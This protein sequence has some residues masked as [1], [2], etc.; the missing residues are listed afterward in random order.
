MFSSGRTFASRS[1]QPVGDS[2][3]RTMLRRP[4]SRR[5]VK[6]SVLA[7]GRQSNVNANQQQDLRPDLLP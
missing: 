3:V 6:G 4:R 2:S 1:V 7:N 5:R